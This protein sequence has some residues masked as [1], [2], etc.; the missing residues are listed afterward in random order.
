M[1]RTMLKFLV[2]LPSTAYATLSTSLDHAKSGLTNLGMK[3]AGI[4]LIWVGY[5][6]YKGDE[7]SKDKFAKVVVGC[8]LIFG[9]PKII[10]FL[11]GWF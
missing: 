1:E 7:D 9:G 3:L 5:K 10:K 4:A 11:K 2:L 8:C 6:Y